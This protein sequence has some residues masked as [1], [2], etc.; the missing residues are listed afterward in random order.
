MIY[1]PAP[2]R[3]CTWTD[4]PS[5]RK[6]LQHKI[7]PTTEKPSFLVGLYFPEYFYHIC[8]NQPANQPA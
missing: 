1:P 5:I 8:F 3:T 7:F 2:I 4:F 6:V